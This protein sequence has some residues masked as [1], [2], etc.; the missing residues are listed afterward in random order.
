MPRSRNVRKIRI[1][2]SPR[3]A[4]ST[5]EKAGITERILSGRDLRRSAD[6]GPSRPRARCRCAL[7]LELQRPRLLGDGRVRPRDGDRLVRRKARTPEWTA[8]RPRVVA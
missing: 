5:L 3:F 8:L 1:A 6:P 2:I 4:T 7:P